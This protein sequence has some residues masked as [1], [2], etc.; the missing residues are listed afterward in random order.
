MQTQTVAKYTNSVSQGC[1]ACGGAHGASECACG[2][3]GC[4]SCESPMR[5]YARPR[6]FSGQLLTEDDLQSL[7]DYVVAKNQ[8]H[9]RMLF[10][11]GVVCGLRVELD[12]CDHQRVRVGSG[13]AL[14]CCGNDISVPCEVEL[15]VVELLRALQRERGVDCGEPCEEQKGGDA[16][17][18]EERRRCYCLYVRYCEQG[19]DLVVPYDSGDSCGASDC[20]ET[21]VR[22]G[23][24]FELRCP[25]VRVRRDLGKLTNSGFFASAHRNVIRDLIEIA[26]RQVEPERARA[27]A[28]GVDQIIADDP[29]RVEVSRDQGEFR[30][31]I[32]EGRF[33]DSLLLAPPLI[34]RRTLEQYCERLLPLCAPC[35]DDAVEIACIEM[36][37]CEVVSICN[38]D[39]DV[40]LSP[41]FLARLGAANWYRDLLHAVCCPAKPDPRVWSGVIDAAGRGVIVRET[42][43]APAA[44]PAARPA[45]GALAEGRGDPVV[46]LLKAIAADD[47]ILPSELVPRLMS[48]A[49]DLVVAP[50]SEPPAAPPRDDE[51]EK[52]K[53][54]V[55]KLTAQITRLERRL[56]D[57]K[58]DNP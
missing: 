58:D 1:S 13:Y 33:A 39:R 36:V 26:G 2:G 53:D 43:P 4:S 55:A 40:V 15:N 47:G 54:E 19:T 18:A 17:P 45:A 7:I 20:Q 37:G 28:L 5:G 11:A 27:I 6:F 24:R 57:K 12:P 52:L 49:F 51:I 29:S 35:N 16:R 30:R 41:G 38:A 31:L 14:D 10:G 46:E 48:R 9:N 50:P 56:R 3:C 8:L 34:L 25:P 22:E 42:T 21:R 32:A 23:F 44:P